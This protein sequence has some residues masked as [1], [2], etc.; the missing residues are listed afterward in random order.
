VEVPGVVETALL[1]AGLVILGG[2][3]AFGVTSWREGERR[4]ARVA[5]AVALGSLPFLLA[6]LLP[7]T[8]RSSPAVQLTLLALAGITAV[9]GA[10]LFLLPIGKVEPEPDEPLNQID[11]R[12]IPFARARLEPGS[13]NYEAYYALRPENKEVDDRTRTLP[14]L[15]SPEASAY[16]P[17]AFASTDASFGLTEVLRPAVNGPVNP[18]QMEVDPASITRF[19]KD[20]TRFYGA[21]TV[22]ITELRPYHIYSHIGRGSGQYGAPVELD[23]RFAIAF[24]VEMNHAMVRAAPHAPTV[25][26]SAREYV[27]AAKTSV[28][29]A[30]WIRLL[31]Y[32]ARAHIDGNYRVVAPLVARDAGLGEIGRMGLLMTPNLG[33]RV[34]LGVVTTDLPLIPDGRKNDRSVLDFCRI[35]QKC[36]E[37]CP[38]KAIPQGDRVEI[39]GAVRWRIND[40][41][42]FRYWNAVGTD[43]ARCMAVCPYSHPDN[44]MHNLVRWAAR[45]SGAARRAVVW[46]DSLFYGRHPAP[47]PYPAWVPSGKE[48]KSTSGER[49]SVY[50]GGH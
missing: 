32:P 39:D 4:A 17:L 1:L 30:N 48:F 43:C 26:E 50:R 21:H 2:F 47:K 7:A 42:C 23:H 19:V 38:P 28:E 29:L 40:A 24:T 49:F 44:L 6:P 13:P 3:V 34:R 8:S 41:M 27:E 37:C 15:L 45:R 33:P 10:V 20:L 16:Q 25:M 11:E 9:A 35:C 36:H 46:L 14:G 31:G 22:G 18:D 12:D 5:S